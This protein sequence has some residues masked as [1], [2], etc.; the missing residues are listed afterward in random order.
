MSSKSIEEMSREELIEE[1]KKAKKEILLQKRRL[2]SK[3]IRT[4]QSQAL[5]ARQ[6][7]EE[8][9]PQKF[10]KPIIVTIYKR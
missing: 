5:R 6:V 7:Q 8:E 1:L 4:S 10:K 3:S 9:E 2:K